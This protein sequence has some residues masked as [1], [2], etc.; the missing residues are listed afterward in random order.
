MLRTLDKSEVCK[1]VI[2]KL[3]FLFNTTIQIYVMPSNS[4]FSPTKYYRN[5]AP[6]IPI[7]HCTVCFHF[8]LEDDFEIAAIQRS[9]CPVCRASAKDTLGAANLLF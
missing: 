6:S 1:W 8:F 7:V 4:P 5:M 3:Y 2:I 9:V